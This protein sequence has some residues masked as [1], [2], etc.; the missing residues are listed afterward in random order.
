MKKKYI[1][2]SQESV[3]MFKNDVLEV[4]SKVHFL[5]PC[6]HFFTCYPVYHLFGLF[7]KKIGIGAYCEYFLL[8]Y[9]LYGHL[10]VH[11]A[12]FYISLCA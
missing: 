6:I 12:P 4:L 7:D 3:R 1:S 8:G 10:L 2:N 5:M 11:H 9:F